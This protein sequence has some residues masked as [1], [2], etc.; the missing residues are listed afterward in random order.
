MVDDEHVSVARE[1]TEESLTD[2]VNRIG[3]VF[4]VFDARTQDSGHI[5]YGVRDVSGRRWFVKTP[6]LDAPNSGGAGRA[7]RSAALE[8]SAAVCTA[9][10]HPALIPMERMVDTAEGVLL[11]S[12]WF[13]GELLRAPAQLRDDPDQA[14]NRFKAL[15]VREIIAALDSVIDVHVRL[16]DAGWVVGDFYDGCLMYD[17]RSRT[18]KVMDFECYQHGSYV[19]RVGR[20]PG[21]TRFMA[22]EELT[23]G[24]TVDAR[25]TVFNLARMVQIFLLERHPDHPACEIATAATH[26]DPSERPAS[27]AGFRQVWREAADVAG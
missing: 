26:H 14:F 5:S 6:G 21:S 25:T 12:E 15:P 24:A 20:L 1:S 17:F 23:A 13:G 9:V 22:P 19:N 11:V 3:E 10:V 8:R 2:V 4:A 16:D 18:V 7:E 27:V